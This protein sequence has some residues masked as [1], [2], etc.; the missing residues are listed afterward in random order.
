MIEY[1]RS[2]GIVP[3]YTCNGHGVTDVVA[4]F[5]AVTCGAVAVSVYDKN[6][7]YDA[8]KKFVDAG[9]TQCNI[10]LML[11][12]QTYD[13]AFEILNDRLT[14]PRL[15][16]LNAIVFLAYK[17]KG[18]NKGQFTTITDIKKYKKIIEFCSQNNISYGCDSCSAPFILKAYED[19]ELY[20]K[21][22]P[23]VEPCEASLFSSY[24]N[25]YGDYFPCS[26]TEDEG[27]WEQGL[28]VLACNDFE[29]DIWN[30]PKTELFRQELLRSS[31]TRVS[32]S[33]CKSQS[34]CRTCP[35]FEGIRC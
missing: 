3:N 9:M 24:V 32:C 15:R 11:S 2:Q 6:K 17:S 10:H 21:V 28:N 5:T 8:I 20:E 27:D 23:M 13:K 7:S 12:E 30:N 19:S 4:A 26:F 25:S 22:A 14:D 33:G 35:T 34:I 18:N 31:A 16:N 29:T 1:A